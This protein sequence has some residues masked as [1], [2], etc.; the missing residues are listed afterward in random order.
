MA[1]IRASCQLATPD[2]RSDGHECPAQCGKS[3]SC[4]PC[5][6]IPCKQ[7]QRRADRTEM[8][9]VRKP[10]SRKPVQLAFALNG[11]TSA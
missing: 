2:S 9:P 6:C 3:C 8:F 4:P 5:G 11:D 7:R 1:D 10:E